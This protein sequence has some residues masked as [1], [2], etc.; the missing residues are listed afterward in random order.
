MSKNPGLFSRIFSKLTGKEEGTEFTGCDRTTADLNIDH[1]PAS[2]HIHKENDKTLKD[3]GINFKDKYILEVKTGLQK[4]KSF[5][6]NNSVIYLGKDRKINPR[7]WILLDSPDVSEEQ[8]ILKW[9]IK[10]KKFALLH[11]A[12]SPV[13]TYVNNTAAPEDKY[14]L[15]DHNSIIKIGTT[16]M[17]VKYVKGQTPESYDL[18]DY[19]ESRK[20]VSLPAHYSSYA[21]KAG[22]DQTMEVSYE[23][24]HMFQ[25]ISGPDRERVITINRDTVEGKLI[26]GRKGGRRKDIELSDE[27]ISDCYATLSLEEEWLCIN[28]EDPAGELIINDV[29]VIKKGLEH[30]DVIKLGNTDIEHYLVGSQITHNYARLKVI[31]GPDTG[32][33][34]ELKANLINIGRKS[35][36]SE[37][38]KKEIELPEDDRSLS[39]QHALIEKRGNKFYLINR[40]EKNLTLLNGIHV[41]E[42][43]PLVSGD[44]IKFGNEVIFLYEYNE[45]PVILRG[46]ELECELSKTPEEKEENFCESADLFSDIR[47]KEGFSATEQEIEPPA[48]NE[49]EIQKRMEEEF[50]AQSRE[51][52]YKRMEEEFAA[53]TGKEVYHGSEPENVTLEKDSETLQEDMVF[54][55]G[56]E[57]WMGLDHI[58]CDANPKHRVRVDPFYIDRYPVTNIEFADFVM[59]TGYTSEGNW[60]DYFSEGKEYHPVVGVTCNDAL[61]YAYWLGKRLPSEAEWEKASR[62]E[63]GFLYPWGNF[64]DPGKLCSKEGNYGEPIPV[65]SH[66]E[67]ASPYGVMST[68]GN[69]WEWTSDHYSHYPYNPCPVEDIN[70]EVV[71]RGGDWLTELEL[72]GSG[73]RAVMFVDEFSASVG[74]RCARPAAGEDT[75]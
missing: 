8:S 2:S 64:W 18:E 10:D 45:A 73:A 9:R 41:N 51:E 17:V 32:S 66:P 4:G 23:E 60:Q 24:A 27:T 48:E 59:I 50:A 15:L 39:R 3:D 58:E 11:V 25:I 52:M 47:E 54:I 55:P 7:N 36:D 29:P 63:E 28:L 38:E 26:I 62:G 34:F 56:G 70:K 19:E 6:L 21:D 13:P 74:F 67:G 61:A 37:E 68:L 35:R 72:L 33:L 12:S 31:E 57:F 30:G 65:D 53:Q 44:K 42:P 71:I 14:T 40:K 69:T 16:E 75:V 22:T 1:I 20:P 43:R 49:E 5:R 46:E